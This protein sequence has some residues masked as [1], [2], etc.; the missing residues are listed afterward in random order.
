MAFQVSAG[1]E[2]KEIDLTNVVPAVSTSIGGFVGPFRWGPVEDI[3][4]I[5][6]ETE[7]ANEFGK[8]KSSGPTGEGFFT[9]ASFLKYGNA[10]KAVRSTDSA[11]KNAVSG[12]V[13]KA[14]TGITVFSNSSPSSAG[15]SGTTTDS[16]SAGSLLGGI[17][18]SSGVISEFTVTSNDG[19]GA[20]IEANYNVS[21]IKVASAGSGYTE[22]D[23][24]SI[25]LGEGQIL[26]IKITTAA[27][28]IPSVL[29]LVT[30]GSNSPGLFT[31]KTPSKFSSVA[32]SSLATANTSPS[33][34]TG[35]QV[36]LTYA[37]KSFSILN[38]GSGYD[39]S[40]SPG[41]RIFGDGTELFPAPS[42]IS[43]SDGDLNSPGSLHG[44]IPVLS[45]AAAS[46]AALIKNEDA[47]ESIKGSLSGDIFARY[48]GA[49]GD[50]TR[51]YIVNAS[52][53]DSLFFNGTSNKVSDQFDT[54]PTGTELHIM[55]TSTQDAFT[56]NG[57]VETEVEKWAF[58]DATDGAKTADGANNYYVDRINQSS[59]W[60]F[61]PSAISSVTTLSGTTGVFLLGSGADQTSVTAG[62]ISTG[63]D[64]LAD[65]ETVDVNLLFSVADSNGDNTVG[66]KVLSVATTRKDVV[67]FVN[68]A[69]ADTQLQSAANSLANVKTYKA[70]LSAPDSY[71]VIG[72]TSAYVYDKYNDRFLYIGTQGHLAGLCANT[73]RVAES[74][75]SPGGFNRGQLRNITKLAYNPKKADRDELYKAG[76]N[77]IVSF[78]GQGVVLFGDKTLQSK[79]SAFDRIN[80]RRLFITLEKA[81][82]TAAKF[83]L[84]E[85]NDEFTRATFR[86]LVE[87]FLRDVQGRR[88]ITD[89][90]VVC[91]ETNNTG[92][93]IDSNRFVADIFIKPARSINFITLNFIA[94]RTGVE[95]SE[96]VGNV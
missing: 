83:Q 36:D 4:L 82:S 37:V 53:K 35:L 49:L 38:G 59:E 88:G 26:P 44:L 60:I 21:A 20:E 80:V 6:S 67:G 79:P 5:G 15:G 27:D 71:G 63:L 61:I 81:I 17:T 34:G 78:P 50:N 52:N 12:G 13:G 48:A 28:G 65:S 64:L 14:I 77:P 92:Q 19:S 8:P 95:F 16:P 96:I 23:E 55:V 30:D 73:D 32:A 43:G 68:P 51:I 58:L 57:T 18:A 1:V 7:L 76:I 87:P 75:F 25:D 94:T 41:L 72:S 74:W 42:T 2:V 56:G 62:D 84:F 69:I 70:S 22:G 66:N 29:G 86:N 40:D 24:V 11:L 31:L 10:L 90:L 89:F 85:L 33:S 39:L 46:T 3:R 54:V 45:G 93:V 91:D 9:A 47:F